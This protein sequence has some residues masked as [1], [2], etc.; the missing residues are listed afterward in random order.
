MAVNNSDKEKAGTK[1]AMISKDS[2]I[3]LIFAIVASI[4]VSACAVLGWSFIEDIG[5]N[6]KVIGELNS[7]NTSLKDNK[8]AG[9]KVRHEL[10]QLNNDGDLKQ[11][12][13]SSEDS[14]LQVILDAMPTW[15]SRS[16]LAAS[17]QNEILNR[18]GVSI[19]TMDVND[20]SAVENQV[21]LG[22]DAEETA[23]LLPIEFSVVLLGDE[24]TIQNTLRDIE[25]TIRPII[26]TD[27]TINLS[28]EYRV[29]LTAKTYY[30]PLMTYK[31]IDKVVER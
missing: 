5:Y 7:T 14:A 13:A 9:D 27:M 1:R 21:N 23:G 17:L 16:S 15:D 6:G 24:T 10:E 8:T 11:L 28:D 18:S 29:T 2:Q 31:L 26:V 22:V 25:R 20:A 4:V 19:Q 12:R 3:V 30:N